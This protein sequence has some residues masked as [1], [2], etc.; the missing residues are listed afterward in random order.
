LE[1]AK[2]NVDNAITMLT[3]HLQWREAYALDTIVDEDFSK[4]KH[5]GKIAIA[6]SFDALEFNSV[7]RRALLGRPR[8]GWGSNPDMEDCQARLQPLLF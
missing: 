8:C 1:T 7:G 4:M 5:S 2:G 3:E 6:I